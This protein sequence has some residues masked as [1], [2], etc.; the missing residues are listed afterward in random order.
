MAKWHVLF[1]VAAAFNFLMGVPLLLVPTWMA[2]AVGM[3]V[4]DDLLFHRIAGALIACFGGLYAFIAND[5]IRYRPLAA[6]GAIGKATAVVVF[7]QAWLAGKV[8]SPAYALA[9]G[10]LAFVVG[11]L[12]FL[13]AAEFKM[14]MHP[15]HDRH[16]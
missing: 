14:S 7:T 1:A 2:S 3:M 13:T 15:Q 9:L 5:P 8:P 12:T 6:L 4:P 16:R 10:D 11:F